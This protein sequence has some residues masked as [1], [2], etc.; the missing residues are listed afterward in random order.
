VPAI[1]DV[2]DLLKAIATLLW[3]VLALLAI[4]RLLPV[5]HSVVESA[6]SRK[7]SIKIAGQELSMEEASQQNRSLIEDLQAKVIDLTKRIDGAQ[8]T[9]A[10]HAKSNV[11]PKLE[12]FNFD[13]DDLGLQKS[14]LQLAE[15]ISRVISQGLNEFSLGPIQQFI[16]AQHNDAWRYYIS[17]D[18]IDDHIQEAEA[19]YDYLTRKLIDSPLSKHAG[20]VASALGIMKH[21]MMGRIQ[22]LRRRQSDA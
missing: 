6:K 21:N 19:L 4:W 8:T 12:L 11:L 10:P 16:I 14:R 17:A 2:S 3:P 7:F 9:G 13:G 18:R 20:E 22:S 5:I 1:S 15:N